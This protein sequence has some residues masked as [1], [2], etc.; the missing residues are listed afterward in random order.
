LRLSDGR[1]LIAFN[2]SAKN[3]SNITLS[4][5]SGHGDASKRIALIE[6]ET[7]SVFSYPFLMRA[8]DGMIRMAYTRKG[9]EIALSSFNEAWIRAL[10]SKMASELKQ[11]KP[12]AP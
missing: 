9:K 8:S 5:A 11:A 2:D 4:I 10:E 7:G 12:A 1:L 3:R 6:Q